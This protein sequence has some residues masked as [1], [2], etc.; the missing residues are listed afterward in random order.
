MQEANA[1]I[2]IGELKREAVV[3]EVMSFSSGEEARG[4]SPTESKRERMPEQE[5]GSTRG[6]V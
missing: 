1:E 3:D 2:T 4:Q 6:N 5:P